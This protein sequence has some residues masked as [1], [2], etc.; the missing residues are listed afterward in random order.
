[1]ACGGSHARGGVG[2]TVACLHHSHSNTGSEPL[3]QPTPQL[4]ATL[5]PLPTE[6]G[7]GLNL[8]PYGSW[9]DSLT[10]EP[11]WELPVGAFRLLTF[12]MI[13]DIVGLI[14]TIFITIFCC[15]CFLFLFLSPTLFL[16]FMSSP[17]HTV[18]RKTWI[19]LIYGSGICLLQNNSR[20]QQCL[21]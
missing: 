1:M 8:H 9:L 3:L 4:M 16:P 13:I 10:A 12:K 5:D 11:R 21:K 19:F 20:V 7:R 17:F 6:Q 15:P 14:S 2:A 18:I